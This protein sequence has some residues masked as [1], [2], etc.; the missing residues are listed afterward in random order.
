MEKVQTSV[1]IIIADDHDLVRSGIAALLSSI[2]GF[3]V[4]A[5][6]RDGDEL[7]KILRTVVPDVVITDISM[8]GM[9]GYTAASRIR[10]EHPGVRVVILSADESVAA[11]KKAVASGACGYI[12]KDAPRFELELAIRTV[13]HSGSY[14]GSRVAHMLLQ[15]PEPQVEDMLTERQLTV[16]TKL[17]Q[18]KSAKEIGFEMGLSSKTIDVHRA[19]IMERLGLH[20]VASLVR[21]AVRMGLVKD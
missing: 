3:E 6:A 15:P 21:Y 13:M 9:D 10:Q 1:R 20:D 14:F 11:V 4:V 2:N 17:A 7:L 8:P 19:R 16:L 5:D 12:R 18:G